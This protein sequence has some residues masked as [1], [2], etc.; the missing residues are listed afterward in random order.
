MCICTI[1]GYPDWR[2]LRWQLFLW[3]TTPIV[4]LPEMVQLLSLVRLWYQII[5]SVLMGLF[6]Q[7][8]PTF[9]NLIGGTYRSIA[10]SNINGCTTSLTDRI[11]FDVL[12]VVSTPIVSASNVTNCGTP[13]GSITITGPG[14]IIGGHTYS[15]NNGISFR[16]VLHSITFRPVYTT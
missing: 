8:S 5:H 9:G 4:L 7:A 10:R 2:S 11:I 16:Q 1:H 15:V 14:S 3:Q 12:A 6:Y 13:N